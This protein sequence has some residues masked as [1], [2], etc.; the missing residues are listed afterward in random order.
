VFIK[1]NEDCAGYVPLMEL[2]TSRSAIEI[3]ADVTKNDVIT[4]SDVVDGDDGR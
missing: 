4:V 2:S 3:P 1:V